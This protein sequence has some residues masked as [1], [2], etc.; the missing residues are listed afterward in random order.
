MTLNVSHIEGYQMLKYHLHN[1]PHIH[2][3]KDDMYGKHYDLDDF[4]K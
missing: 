1:Y 4:V 3:H 2:I